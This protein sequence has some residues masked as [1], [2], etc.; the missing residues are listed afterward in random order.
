MPPEGSRSLEHVLLVDS[1]MHYQKDEDVSFFEIWFFLPHGD[2]YAGFPDYVRGVKRGD[3]CIISD[4]DR[5]AP[6]SFAVFG[7]DD[8]EEDDF[9][10]GVRVRRDPPH[11]EF[12]FCARKL[13]EPMACV[14]I[15]LGEHV[16]QLV[17]PDWIP[18]GSPKPTS[19]PPTKRQDSQSAHENGE[20]R[21]RARSPSLLRW[22]RVGTDD[23]PISPLM[24]SRVRVASIQWVRDPFRAVCEVLLSPLLPERERPGGTKTVNAKG[25][26]TGAAGM[27]NGVFSGPDSLHV[28]RVAVLTDPGLGMPIE[29]LETSVGFEVCGMEEVD[30]LEGGSAYRRH[31]FKRTKG[32]PPEGGHR[33]I[34]LQVGQERVALSVPASLVE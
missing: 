4:G 10:D 11:F 22:E 6:D 5:F 8:C 7:E 17:L 13:R 33:V 3:V 28:P 25:E 16:L 30:Q 1:R 12:T 21:G 32:P 15:R 29:W 23:P 18:G 20:Q 27:A 26:G 2:R 34:L 19:L 14:E 9:G 24:N 31:T